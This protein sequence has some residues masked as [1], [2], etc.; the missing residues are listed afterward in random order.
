MMRVLLYLANGRTLFDF[1]LIVTFQRR[2]LVVF[3][4]TVEG[5]Q[6]FLTSGSQREFE[7]VIL[8]FHIRLLVSSAVLQILKR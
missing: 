5:A 7:V 6:T 8:G 4:S 1:C 3:Y 2:V